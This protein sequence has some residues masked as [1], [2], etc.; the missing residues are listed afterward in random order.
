MERTEI[1]NYLSKS[2]S[3]PRFNHCLGVEKMALELV[4]GFGVAPELV[5]PAALLHDLCR[6]YQRDLLLKLAGNFG[7][8]ID[9][10]ER[11]E[12]LLLHGLVAAALAKS[13]LGIEQT[14]I[15]E[16]ISYHITGIPQAKALTRLIFVADFIEPGRTYEVAGILRRE[17]FRLKPEQL[18]LK[19]YNCTITYVVNKGY[20]I[21]PRSIHGRNELIMKG[22]KEN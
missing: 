14:D 4:A 2:V 19:V 13:E 18:L 20:L 6:E 12:P 7:I 8:V 16:A 10:I 11:L 17:A 22:V 9:E 3:P 5:T 21:H 15:L 1:L